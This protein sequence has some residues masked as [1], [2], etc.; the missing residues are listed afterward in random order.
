MNVPPISFLT[1]I[2]VVVTG[3]VIEL[4]L[5]RG[6]SAIPTATRAAFLTIFWI[7]LALGFMWF[8]VVEKGVV[9][10]LTF[11][12]AWLMEWSLSLD[13]I[14]VFIG[15]FSVMK[16]PEE[17]ITSGLFFG[18]LLAILLRILFLGAGL[19]LMHKIPWILYVM[20]GFLIYSGSWMIW[21]HPG[22]LAFPGSGSTFRWLQKWL[23][24]SR[25]APAGIY[26]QWKEGRP[27]FTS[28]LLTVV[29]LAFTDLV[30]A[31]DSIPAVLVISGDPL[32]VFTS[33]I[34]AVLGLR[35]LFFLVRRLSTKFSR[36]QQGIALILIF[37]GC[38]MVAGILHIRVPVLISL[39]VIASCVGIPIFLSLVNPVKINDGE[40]TEIG[41]R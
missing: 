17:D 3:L 14:F 34:L 7:L 29:L 22:R 9:T 23:P 27:W 15:V 35:S 21:R 41:D 39:V 38:K 1:F 26:I 19:A 20:G 36:L 30:F 12:S 25:D 5:L 28:L 31:L 24:V 32:V 18:I 11:I 40:I 33:N 13:N 4:G 16:I 10:G 6:L 37:V 8:L 2:A